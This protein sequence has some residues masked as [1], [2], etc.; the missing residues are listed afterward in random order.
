MARILAVTDGMLGMRSATIELGR[1]LVAA[2]HSVTFAGPEA[3]RERA[4]DHGLA[5]IALSTNETM[6]F[7]ARDGERGLL[8]RLRDIAERRREARRVTGV[9]AF[10]D[11]LRRETPDLLLLDAEMHEHIIVAIGAG[12]P[13]A[14]MNTFCSV[15]RLP[16]S[17]PP[18]TLVTP[19]QGLRGTRPAIAISWLAFRLRKRLR[20]L[21]LRWKR[22]GC[23]RPGLLRRLA[24]EHGV[25]PR[26][27][28]D[29]SQWPI[30][31]AYPRVPALSL[32]ALEFEFVTEP[33]PG[34]AFVGPMQLTKRGPDTLPEEERRRLDRVLERHATS[35]SDRR[36][37]YAGFGSVFTVQGRWLQALFEAVGRRPEW[38]LVLSLGGSAS[39]D[40]LGSLP[41]N[42]HAFRWP[43]QLELL[44]RADAAIVHGG[45]NTID[46]CVLAR[47]PM[48][49]CCG[50]QTDMAG[51]TARVAHHGIGL[52]AEPRRDRASD[53][54]RRLDQLL[55]DQDV[56]QRLK[57]MQRAYLAYAEDGVAARAVKQILSDSAGK[58]V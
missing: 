25:D 57:S 12:V 15:W 6:A 31:W 1:Q 26:R 17:P 10:V 5:F 42:V 24:R 56:A 8:E 39:M 46:E 3:D 21:R 53:I 19:G 34:V 20:F 55:G 22:M 23:D 13:L 38:D 41:E 49:V 48:L 4:R 47:V 45:I 2:G 9:D 54:E 51:N 16:G 11:L 37:L 44:A 52:A 18:H 7:Y 30:P 29:M 32:H 14:L 58:R 36:L 43:P 27:E 40:A 33:P 28:T 35:D 50:F